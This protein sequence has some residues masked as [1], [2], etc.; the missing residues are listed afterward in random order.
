MKSTT[1]MPDADI[2]KDERSDM[3]DSA[4]PTTRDVDS[5]E[6]SA[7]GLPA[8]VLHPDEVQGASD[9]LSSTSKGG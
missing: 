8:K 5:K 9:P 4:A 3:P 1:V 2:R 7:E 6:K